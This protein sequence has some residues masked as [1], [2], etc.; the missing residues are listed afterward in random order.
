[1]GSVVAPTSPVSGRILAP[2]PAVLH[3]GVERVPV[4]LAPSQSNPGAWVVV[5]Y[6]RPSVRLPV[7]ADGFI[8][9]IGFLE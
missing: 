1:M 4:T 6:P 2:G 8:P 7:R 5:G 3:V 9:G